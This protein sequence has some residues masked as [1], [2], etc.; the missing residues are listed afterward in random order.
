MVAWGDP[1]PAVIFGVGMLA[2]LWRPAR[3][4]MV[5]VATLAALFGYIA[6]RGVVGI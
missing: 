1:V 3:L 6:L 2:M 5:A 4:R